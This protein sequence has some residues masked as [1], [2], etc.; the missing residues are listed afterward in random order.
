[1]L[2]I[3]KIILNH[4]L[5]NEGSEGLNALDSILLDLALFHDCFIPNDKGPIDQL[6]DSRL[7]QIGVIVLSWRELLVLKVVNRQRKVKGKWS[8]RLDKLR[9]ISSLNKAHISEIKRQISKD[10]GV[11]PCV[12][13]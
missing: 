7:E 6:K 2:V 9:K 3:L 8:D 10:Q 11:F 12:D 5:F 1:L 4:L 13:P